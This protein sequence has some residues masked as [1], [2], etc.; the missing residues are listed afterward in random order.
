MSEKK[1]ALYDRHIALG[2]KMVPFAGFIMPIQYSSIIEEHQNV[3]K[4]VGAFDVSHM[5]EFIFRGTDAGEFLNHMTTNNVASLEIGQIQYSSMLYD[6]GGVVD[7]LLVYR[8]ADHYMVVVNAANLQKDYDWFKSHLQGDVTLDDR[9]DA[10]TLIAVQGPKAEPLVSELADQEVADVEYYHFREGKLLGRP[11][12]FSR[13]GYTGEDGFELYIALEDS[14]PVWDKLFSAGKKYGLLPTGLGARDSLR[15]EV[16]YR[17]YGNDMD[18]TT[19]PI[20]AGLGWIV[21]TKKKGGF[22]GKDAV[23]KA[24][25]EMTRKLVGF[26]LTGKGIARH[27]F[28][29]LAQGERIGEV[30]SGGY[31]PATDKVIGLAYV[32]VPYDEIGTELE[33]DVRGKRLPAK[34][35]PT[36]F[37]VRNN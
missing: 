20:E 13:T 27:Q 16:C 33:I 19:N 12:I 17:L 5:G 30:T 2:A 1:T 9:S 10:I 3:R 35:V 25:E 22:I 23:L 11:C 18:Q 26:E 31:S 29:V 34:V 8:F 37:Y 4:N 36:P 7:D 6:D 24:K 28:P 15:L 32:S 14:L 21:K